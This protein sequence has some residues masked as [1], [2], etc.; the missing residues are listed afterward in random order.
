MDQQRA[1]EFKWQVKEFE[2]S[3]LGQGSPESIVWKAYVP[4]DAYNYFM[5]WKAC[6]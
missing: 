2:L 6:G 5:K 1:K 4:G 3:Y